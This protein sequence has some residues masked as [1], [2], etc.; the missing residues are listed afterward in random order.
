[1]CSLGDGAEEDKREYHSLG[2]GQLINLFSKKKGVA[3]AF[4]NFLDV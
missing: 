3:W 4:Y 2:S 1:M